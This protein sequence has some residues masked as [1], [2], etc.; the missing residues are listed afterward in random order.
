[1][2]LPVPKL[3]RSLGIV[4]LWRTTCRSGC[5]LNLLH[6]VFVC[7]VS[8]SFHFSSRFSFGDVDR[9]VKVLPQCSAKVCVLLFAATS[10]RPPQ[11]TQRGR[12]RRQGRGATKLQ[13][14]SKRV[15]HASMQNIKAVVRAPDIWKTLI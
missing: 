3:R 10:L 5:D 1:R 11:K 12:G 7:L 6:V 15:V 9:H 8:F 4:L 2:A 14:K 13:R